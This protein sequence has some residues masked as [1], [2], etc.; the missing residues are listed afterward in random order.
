MGYCE[1]HTNCLESF[2]NF[3]GYVLA[4]ITWPHFTA[5]GHTTLLWTKVE[6]YIRKKW[7]EGYVTAKN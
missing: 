6:F 1:G 5:E 3:V 2:L 7:F 4:Y